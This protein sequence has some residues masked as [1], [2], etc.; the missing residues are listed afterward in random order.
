[1]CCFLGLV[2]LY[3]IA[4]AFS[5]NHPYLGF[6]LYPT[7]QVSA[8]E[9]RLGGT[10]RIRTSPG[11]RLGPGSRTSGEEG[12]MAGA[13]A[14]RDARTRPRDRRGRVTSLPEGVM[15]SGHVVIGFPAGHEKGRRANACPYN[16]HL[17]AP[18]PPKSY[19]SLRRSPSCPPPSSAPRPFAPP[20]ASP[21]PP[22]ASPVWYAQCS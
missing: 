21:P 17:I 3:L 15:G 14:R 19:L 4:L 13:E 5:A 9:R 10:Y 18:R 16:S 12:V 1:M 8:R 11:A 20:S 2:L 7:I 22:P 6:T